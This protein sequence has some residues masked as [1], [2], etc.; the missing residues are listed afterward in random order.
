MKT[1]SRQYQEYP[2]LPKPFYN[3]SGKKV[4]EF[5]SPTEIVLDL[6]FIMTRDKRLSTDTSYMKIEQKLSGDDIDAIRLLKIEVCDGIV[7]LYVQELES[8]KTYTLEWNM[9]YSEGYFLWSLCDMGTILSFSIDRR[10]TE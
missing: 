5:K 7:Q 10:I 9:S 6:P 8:K 3:S 2:N 4:L 1:G